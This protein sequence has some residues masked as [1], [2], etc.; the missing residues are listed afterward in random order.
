VEEGLVGPDCERRGG[1]G[2]VRAGNPLSP[3]PKRSVARGKSLCFYGPQRS[4]EKVFSRLEKRWW[5]GKKKKRQSDLEEMGGEKQQ[6]KSTRFREGLKKVCWRGGACVKRKRGN[7][8]AQNVQFPGISEK[9]KT[10]KKNFQRESCVREGGGSEGGGMEER[11]VLHEGVF[12]PKSMFGR[13]G[14]EVPCPG[15]KKRGYD[16]E[17][18][19]LRQKSMRGRGKNP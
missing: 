9:R 12:N 8:E 10:A 14:G 3:G 15:R 18:P 7:L 11:G 2:D 19:K 17:S 5:P 4:P 16:K 13:K 6:K 1:G